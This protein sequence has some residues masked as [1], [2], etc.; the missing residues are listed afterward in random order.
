MIWEVSPAAV[1]LIILLIKRRL[2]YTNIGQIPNAQKILCGKESF[3]FNSTIPKNPYTCKWALQYVNWNF[4]DVELFTA[5]YLNNFLSDSVYYLIKLCSI[6]L[7]RYI[8]DSDYGNVCNVR[9]VVGIRIELS[10]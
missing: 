1:I 3:N 6:L 9:C 4:L 10:S 2:V 7:N 5:F 8:S